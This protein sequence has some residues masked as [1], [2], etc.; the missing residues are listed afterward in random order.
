MS[1]EKN[2]P[3]DDVIKANLVQSMVRHLE[4]SE[5]PQIQFEAAWVLTTIVSGTSLQT[6]HV[7][8]SG[9]VKP[10]IK[11]I[12]SPHQ[13]VCEQAILALGNI[14]GDGPESRDYVIKCGIIDPLLAL[15]RPDIPNAITRNVI[16]SFLNVCRCKNP[17]VPM[18][19]LQLIL[20]SLSSLLY[21]K[22]NEIVTNACWAFAYI[23]D[24]RNEK[25]EAVIK[26]GMFFFEFF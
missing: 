16:W 23:T 8:E 7:V 19:V 2:P 5:N 18:S 17:T 22:D 25:I 4:N 21:S 3:I 11:L 20:P 15:V 14:I 1:R 10:L 6:K 9:A 13:N 24:N 12:S 26:T